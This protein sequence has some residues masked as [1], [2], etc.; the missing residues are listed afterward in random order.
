[1]VSIT[2]F[3]SRN[4]AGV[5]DS[6]NQNLVADYQRADFFFGEWE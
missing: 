2:Q 6:G 1:M 5:D 3:T 4:A